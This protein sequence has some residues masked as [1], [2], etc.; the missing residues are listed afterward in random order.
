MTSVE[1]PNIRSK[2]S[3]SLRK[4]DACGPEVACVRLRG[5]GTMSIAHNA[6]TDVTRT[7]STV[8]WQCN[9]YILYKH[10]EHSGHVVLVM[11]C[12]ACENALLD[13]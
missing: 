12:S 5:R 1:I 9:L 6:S 3:Y 4:D 8:F 2:A 10:S 13:A 11:V 7:T